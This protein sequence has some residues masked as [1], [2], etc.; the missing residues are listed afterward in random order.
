MSH[1]ITRTQVSPTVLVHVDRNVGDRRGRAATIFVDHADLTAVQVREAAQA[2]LLPGEHL[3]GDCARR[4]GL[5]DMPHR[6]EFA[7]F[8]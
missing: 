8:A 2:F 7:V 5:E 6:F 4:T 3:Q 1:T